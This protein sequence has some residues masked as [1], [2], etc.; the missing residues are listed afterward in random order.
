MVYTLAA[1]VCDLTAIQ[2][3][4]SAANTY[5]VSSAPC[6][7]QDGTLRRTE[8]CLSP[9]PA[10]GPDG[11]SGFRISPVDRLISPSCRKPPP[12]IRP[13]GDR[14]AQNWIRH[15]SLTSNDRFDSIG[16]CHLPPYNNTKD[17]SSPSGCVYQSRPQRRAFLG[18]LVPSACI[19][20]DETRPTTSNLRCIHLA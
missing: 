8:A 11:S 14:I 7:I 6:G 4:P 3:S 1:K 20:A 5:P 2:R 10:S 19:F 13:E 16:F 17:G 15:Q 9:P 18:R 12:Q